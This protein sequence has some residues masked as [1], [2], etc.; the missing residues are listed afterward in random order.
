MCPELNL[1]FPLISSIPLDPFPPFSTL[2]NAT[3]S[4]QLPK[5]AQH[6]RVQALEP[7]YL[8]PNPCLLLSLNSH[9]FSSG[10]S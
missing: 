9:T 2:I 1:Y 10:F 7:D 4:P 3:I 8:A 5:A 6:L